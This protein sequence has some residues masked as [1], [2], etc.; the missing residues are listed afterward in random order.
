MK[1]IKKF[2]NNELLTFTDDNY[3]NLIKIYIDDNY[4]KSNIKKGYQINLINSSKGSYKGSFMNNYICKKFISNQ[5]VNLTNI[6]SNKILNYCK[7]FLLSQNEYYNCLF[8]YKKYNYYWLL[9]TIGATG[10]NCF[11]RINTDGTY[12]YNSA[13][14]SCGFVPFFMKRREKHDKN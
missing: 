13:W 7:Y 2:K 14:W 5:K 4:G 11:R 1:I 10:T 8:R 9:R 12:S 3:Q 6:E